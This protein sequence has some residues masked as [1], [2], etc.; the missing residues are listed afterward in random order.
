VI[1]QR[2][3]EHRVYISARDAGG[4]EISLSVFED[5]LAS[6]QQVPADVPAVRAVIPAFLAARF[7]AAER[8]KAM[9]AMGGKEES[10][11]AVTE[12]LRWLVRSQEEDGHWGMSEGRFRAA[13]T[14]LS[15]LCFLGH[16]ETMASPEFGPA[17]KKGIDWLIRNGN[18]HQ[19]RLSMEPAFSQAG[20]YAHAIATYALSEYYTI[21]GDERVAELLK[22]AVGYIMEGQASDGG[23]MYSY[24]Q[25]TPSDTSVSGWQIQA[26]K[27]AQLS[28][29]KI[30]GLEG[31]LQK[32]ELNLE[33]V[34]GPG[35]GFGYRT[36]DR[37]LYSLTG[38]GLLCTYLLKPDDDRRIRAAVAFILNK[39][40]TQF[41]VDYRGETGDL[42]SWY[43]TTRALAHIGGPAWKKWNDWMQDQLIRNQ[44]VDGSWPPMAGKTPGFY[45]RQA[46]GMGPVF[47][48][49]FCVLIL[50]AY[51]RYQ[52]P[53]QANP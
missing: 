27:A 53:P 34:Q 12:G 42:Y 46:E 11:K 26:L 6:V 36:A 50:E 37:E 45:Q 28:G 19:G 9:A 5:A 48:T 29:L 2:A 4:R 21:S 35:G 8:A 23:W 43:Y 22:S 40:A 13:M 17:V 52:T 38:V 3:Q 51:Y 44:S 30:E 31:T 25:S 39:A 47:R 16:G 20:V 15:L 10:E 32:A 41:P 7:G 18:S 49:T 1:L 14:G 33:R 24:D